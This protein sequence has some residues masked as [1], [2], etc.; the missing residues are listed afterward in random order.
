[1]PAM[2]ILV[3]SDSHR[4]LGALA[5]AL[6]K[7]A[8]DV[9]LVAHLGDGVEDLAP[10]ASY[11][12]VGL[13]SVAAVRGNEDPDPDLPALRL[14]EAEGR[15]ALLVHG[16]LER[17]GEGL[18]RALGAAEAAG[19][20]LLLFGHTHRPFM[21]EYRGVLAVNPGSISRPRGRD[22]PTFA[23]VEVPREAG[24]WFEVR[25]FEVESGFRRVREIDA[26]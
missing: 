9:D 20:G 3:V 12:R 5:A 11:A 17:A 24:S 8:R 22:R 19:A 21:E 4:S 18:E 23:L 25:F 15:R 2:R 10:A 14:I 26:P 7:F 6:R 13:P 1:M 16:H